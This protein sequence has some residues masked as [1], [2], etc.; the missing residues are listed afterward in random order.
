[1]KKKLAP[2]LALS[3]LLAS[4]G[5]QKYGESDAPEVFTPILTRSELEESLNLGTQFLLAHQ[6]EAG[7]FD[8]EYNF[9]TGGFTEEDNAVRQAGALWGLT[10]INL[11][12]PSSEL[13]TAIEKSLAFFKENSFTV[14]DRLCIA[15]PD[16]EDGNTGTQALVTLALID[17]LRSDT[18]MNRET[19]EADLETYLKCLVSLRLQEGQFYSSYEEED[20]EDMGEGY[21]RPS[22]Y[23]DGEALLA[24]IKAVKYAG[25]EEYAEL[26]T[27]SAEA[28]Y[29]A[30]VVDALEKDSDSDTTKGF[31]QW[32]SMAFYELYTSDWTDEKY[33]DWTTTLAYWMLDTHKVLT[34]TKNT[35]YAF[36]GILHAYELARLT[37][38][39][40]AM[41]KFASAADS[42]L[43][44]LIGWQVTNEDTTD[45]LGVGGVRNESTGETLRIDVTQHQMHALILALKYLY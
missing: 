39:E 38:N 40:E 44:K 6:K 24:L 27:D 13:Q 26:A 43:S 4:C 14:E 22:P 21:G 29:Q 36:E 11:Y 8:Y 18:A 30:N 45:P 3:V 42:G 34:R 5:P 2:I 33:A 41:N 32:G 10:L 12:S 28:M 25:Y 16:E 17:Y 20:P 15:Y 23:Y 9:V 1:M 19:Y 7:N 35:G 37:E 31:Y